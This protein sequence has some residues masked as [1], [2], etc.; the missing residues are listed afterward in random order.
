MHTSN[1]L[2]NAIKLSPIALAIGLATAPV[3]AEL[4]DDI[5]TGIKEGSTKLSMRYRYE[6]VDQDGKDKEANASTLK[7]RI[8]YTSAPISGFIAGVEADHVLV[9]GNDNYNSTENGKTEYP[10]VADPK[11]T[12]L[13]QAFLKYV[14]FEDTTATLGRQRINLGDQRFVGGVGWRQNEQTYDGGRVEYAFS[15]ALSVDAS[16]I[17]NVN[18]IFGPDGA[19]SDLHGNIGALNLTYD[20]GKFGKVTAFDYYLD[21]DNNDGLSSNTVGFVYNGG[22]ALSETTKL[23]LKASYAM[24]SDAGDNP[25]SYDAD[26]YL[27]EGSVK[28][29]PV[30]VSAGYEVLGSDDGVSFKTPLATLHKFQG[31]ADKFLVTPGD[32]VVDTYVKVAGSVAG[33]KLAAFYHNFESDEGSTDYG[34]EIDLVASYKINK[35]FGILGKYASYDAD[36]H[37]T[38]TDKFWLQLTSTF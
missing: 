9:V 33:V 20:A 8:T 15:E 37:A 30:S 11:G 26:Y 32:G 35:H 38:D 16:Y 14:G 10:V 34:T 29:K 18:R 13:N 31:F 22:Y 3:Q 36:D 24:Q 7:S 12:D 21:F 6:Y 28:F 25:A 1:T 5:A 2:K 19:D 27:V 4:L 23:G 17:W